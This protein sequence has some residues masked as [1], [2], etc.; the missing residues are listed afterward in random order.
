MKEFAMARQPANAAPSAPS[1]DAA[2]LKNYT[3]IEPI[4]QD[5][6]AII[7]RARHETLDR[8]VRV[9]ILRRPGW[10]SISRS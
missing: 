1:G 7:Y 9:H 10:V 6:L 5:E 3:L 2:E 4:G 8:E